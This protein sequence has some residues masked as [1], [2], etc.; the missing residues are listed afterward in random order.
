M[1]KVIIIQKINNNTISYKKVPIKY[2]SIKQREH[3]GIL[4]NNYE[5][6]KFL[7][8]NYNSNSE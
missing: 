4:K 1:T 6:I 8:K 7:K 2:L 3:L 5:T